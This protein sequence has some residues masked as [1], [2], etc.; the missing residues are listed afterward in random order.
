MAWFIKESPLVKKYKKYR[1]VGQALNNQVLE[2]FGDGR[3]GEATRLLGIRKG[4][5]IILEDENQMQPL[6]DFTLYDCRQDGK[7]AVEQY[8]AEIGG[9]TKIEREL[10]AGMLHSYTS[11][12][13]V[14]SIR[15]AESA[16]VLSDLLTEQEPVKIIDL[17]FSETAVPGLLIFLRLIPLD[18]FNMSAGFS[19][20]FSGDR[21]EHLLRQHKILL[22]KVKS[23]ETAVKR[24]VAFFKLNQRI[25]LGM[26]Y[27]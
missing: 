24:F 2:T 7:N 13:R 19:F 11:L 22:R 4:K 26:G 1:K 3:I 20:I 21:E 18:D 12:F 14:E 9:K 8:Q 17:G 5:T 23:E 16:L 15:K 10:L 25:G 6:M 27:N